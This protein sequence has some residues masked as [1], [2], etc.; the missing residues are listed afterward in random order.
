VWYLSRRVK[1]R[2]LVSEHVD[3]ILLGLTFLEENQCVWHFAERW[4]RIAN[5]EYQLFAH[6]V[7]WSVRRVTLQED[8]VLPCQQMVKAQ[9]VYRTL[10]PS[11][12][13]W[14]TKPFEVASGLRLARTMVA[15]RPVPDSQH[16]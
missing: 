3:E 7:T 12:S 13:Q 2:C 15:D 8:T 1:V 11:T 10:A 5:H 16:Q 9:T 6:K 4:I 14:V